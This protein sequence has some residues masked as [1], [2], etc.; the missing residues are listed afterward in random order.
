MNL[1]K[2]DLRLLLIFREKLLHEQVMRVSLLVSATLS[3]RDEQNVLRASEWC[4]VSSASL[5]TEGRGGIDRGYIQQADEFCEM[6]RF[7]G[8]LVRFSVDLYFGADF[9]SASS[10]TDEVV[11]QKSSECILWPLRP[12]VPAPMMIRSLSK[13]PICRE[14]FHQ[15]EKGNRNKP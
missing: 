13:D 5:S 11:A 12:A 9:A 6:F 14:F 7:P 4:S 8:D 10:K 3:R 15:P 1:L 2:G